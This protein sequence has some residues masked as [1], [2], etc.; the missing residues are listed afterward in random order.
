MAD[1][2]ENDDARSSV[3]SSSSVQMLES[4]GTSIKL[5]KYTFS[6]ETRLLLLQCVREFDAHLAGH[7][8]KD[9]LFSQVLEK[10]NSNLPASTLVKHQKPGLKTLRDKLRSMLALRKKQNEKNAAASGISEAVTEESQL[11]DDF[12]LEIAEAKEQQHEEKKALSQ[13]EKNLIQAGEDIQRKGLERSRKNNSAGKKRSRGDDDEWTQF[14]QQVSENMN[15]QK[16]LRMEEV[17]IRKREISLQEEKYENGKEE[18]ARRQETEKTTLDLL[19]LLVKK[20][21]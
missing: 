2:T 15:E 1:P 20:L 8:E 12:I 19:K 4:P 14:V 18:R 21:E 3:E 7:G 17:E 11:L 5:K 9:K 16:K 10:F 6:K 13:T